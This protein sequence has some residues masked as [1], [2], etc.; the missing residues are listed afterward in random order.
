MRRKARSHRFLIHI[1]GA[2]ETC[3]VHVVGGRSLPLE[4]LRIRG[5]A[6]RIDP[7]ILDG[8]LEVRCSGIVAVENKGG[9]DLV[10]EHI[11]A[12]VDVQEDENHHQ[13]MDGRHCDP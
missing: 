1:V 4:Q 12:A 7:H 3:T 2:D 11:E 10:G 6:R 9:S 8:A 13:E 5:L